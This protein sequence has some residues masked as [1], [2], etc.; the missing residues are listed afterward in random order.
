MAKS[1]GIIILRCSLTIDLKILQGEVFVVI[2]FMST[3]GPDKMFLLGVL[4]KHE[5]SDW[6]WVISDSSFPE[7]LWKKWNDKWHDRINL[8]I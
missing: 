5:K 2:L 8:P 3:Y 1:I 7:S 6:Q 4:T